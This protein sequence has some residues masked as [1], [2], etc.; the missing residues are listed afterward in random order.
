MKQ[1]LLPV[2]FLLAASTSAAESRRVPWIEDISWAEVVSQAQNK[3]A[4]PILIDFYAQWCRPC[5]M[6]D[7][8]VYNESEVIEELGNVLTFK[9]D[10]DKMEYKAL[11]EK[12]NISV[13]PTLVW[14]DDQGREL[15]RFTGYQNKDQFLEIIRSIRVGG[16]TFYRIMD[17]Q[18][19]RPED[20][21][22]LFDLAR[23]HVEQGDLVRG[24]ILYRRLIGLRFQ[25]DKSVVTNGMLG[26]AAME[27][28][29]GRHGQARGLAR[30]AT[31]VYSAEDTTALADLMAVAEFQ[32]ALGDTLG[33]LD[34]YRTLIG[35]DDTNHVALDGFVRM[36]VIADREL[37]QATKYG[38]RAVIMS[39][40]DPRIMASLARC[41][42]GRNNYT[43]AKR[44]MGKALESDPGNARFAEDLLAYQLAME[45]SPFQYRGRRR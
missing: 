15:D 24:E 19:S 41:Y 22:L 9:V 16:N 32:R 11:K 20:P 18:A 31:M 34:T 44:W 12:F 3:P 28:K 43:K 27:E 36:A 1:H 25:G 39:D 7:V 30:R 14:L 38:L 6:L 35:L 33:V 21:G 13:L 37:E 26:L 23:R 29:A 5:K 2:L 8:M 45:K 4:R 10:V 42:A 40:G 17:L